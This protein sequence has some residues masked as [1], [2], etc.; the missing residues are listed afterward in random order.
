[1][2]SNVSVIA[3]AFCKTESK[4]EDEEIDEKNSGVGTGYCTSDG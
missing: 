1:M 2:R 4:L 3:E